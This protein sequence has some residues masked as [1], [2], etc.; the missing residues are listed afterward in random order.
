MPLLGQ[1]LRPRDYG[2]GSCAVCGRAFPRKSSRSLSCTDCRQELKKIRERQAPERTKLYGE[3]YRAANKDRI[4]QRQRAHYEA[5]RDEYISRSAESRA[6]QMATDP[7]KLRARARKYAAKRR[8]ADPD[9]WRE[10]RRNYVAARKLIDPGFKLNELMSRAVRRGLEDG[11]GGR[12][13]EALVGY[14]LEQLKAHLERQFLPGMSWSNHTRNG[15]HID[16]IVPLSTFD[17]RSPDDAEFQA[18][19]ALT[20]LRPMW[21]DDNLKKGAKRRSL[22]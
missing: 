10:H 13:W 18:A 4:A 19:W 3:K 22:L 14:S 6:R 20:N 21:A 1:K 2:T 12:A 15:W 8:A 16:H 5:N 9:G 11:K 17:F 7:E